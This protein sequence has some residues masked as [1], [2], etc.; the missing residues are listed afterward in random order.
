MRSVQ[1]K[2]G[3]AKLSCLGGAFAAL[4]LWCSPAR[5]DAIADW[6]AIAAGAV[7]ASG[8]ADSYERSH[9]MA[10][11]NV[12]MFEAVN[13][14]EAKHASWLLARP[15]KPFGASNEAAA[16]AAAHYVLSQLYPEQRV[17]FSVALVRSLAAIPDG[18]EKFVG[19][20]MGTR[21][22]M[23]IY[24]I[25]ESGGGGSIQLSATTPAAGPSR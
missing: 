19:Q 25:L 3:F 20:V 24:A 21:L 1:M 18:E 9:V 6:N 15:S 16:A 4:L 17:N 22:G 13:F 5:A 10:M 2:D 14:N 11:V 7:S 23:S 12:A 8:R